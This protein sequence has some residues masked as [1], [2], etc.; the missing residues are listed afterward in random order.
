[1]KI[2][3]ILL[4]IVAVVTSTFVMAAPSQY[5]N[6]SSITIVRERSSGYDITNGANTAANV[7]SKAFQIHKEKQGWVLTLDKDQDFKIKPLYKYIL[8][9]WESPLPLTMGKSLDPKYPVKI[10]NQLTGD[11]VLAQKG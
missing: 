3:K 8:K 6:K 2:K 1:M 4:G 5:I 9:S 10:T 7:A 11:F